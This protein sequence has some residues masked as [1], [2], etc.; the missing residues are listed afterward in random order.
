M[1]R[2][3]TPQEKARN[4][5]RKQEV[6]KSMSK[7]DDVPRHL[8]DYATPRR[9]FQTTWKLTVGD[10]RFRW[11]CRKCKTF[12]CW[13]KETNYWLLEWLTLSKMFPVSGASWQSQ[14][15]TATFLLLIH[16]KKVAEM[17]SWLSFFKV[18]VTGQSQEPSLGRR[19]CTASIFLNYQAFPGQT[20][21]LMI[22]PLSFTVQK[23]NW[24]F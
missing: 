11:A 6:R 20:R 22:T 18:A 10:A 23:N 2:I 13:W 21:L 1:K 8:L 12:I 9:C 15:L 4:A 3:R 5:L 17:R 7:I 19:Y 24:F 14:Q 16:K